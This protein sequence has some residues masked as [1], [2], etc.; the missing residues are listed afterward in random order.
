MLAQKWKT[1][2]GLRWRL[3][4]VSGSMVWGFYALHIPICEL[5]SFLR[6]LRS[7]ARTIK[8]PRDWKRVTV[9]PPRV[10]TFLQKSVLHFFLRNPWRIWRPLPTH[11]SVIS[12]SDASIQGWGIIVAGKAFWGPWN[13][14]T[15]SVDIFCLELMAAEKAIVK[16]CSALTNSL[17]CIHIDNEG[18]A[19]S[20]VK[21]RCS[22]SWGNCILQRVSRLLS[23]TSCRLLVHWVPS[24]DQKADYWSRI[25]FEEN[26]Q[27]SFCQNKKV[28]HSRCQ[29]G[30]RIGIW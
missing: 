4:K 2:S 17:L 1:N 24:E 7:L 28:P 3:W 5:D 29:E 23:K 25:P 14:P 13:F 8:S 30:K 9:I 21:M 19:K 20:L 10:R 12:W 6:W 16:M 15:S 18:A 22:N 27:E 11:V 26:W